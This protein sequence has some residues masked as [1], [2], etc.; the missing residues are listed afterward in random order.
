MFNH[1]RFDGK[2]SSY[3]QNVLNRLQKHLSDEKLHIVAA[4][5]AGKTILG[6]E[7]IRRIGKKC[8]ILAPTITI[9]NQWELRLK[10]LFLTDTQI[11][12]QLISMDILSPKTI[13][14]ST[15]QGLLAA[16]CGHKE[17]NDVSSADIVA[18]SDI[19]ETDTT[20]TRYEFEYEL[21]CLKDFL[22]EYK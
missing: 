10:Q 11:A 1:L 12:S 16:L 4:P 2:W 9:K 19:E 18:N 8:L 6:L 15:Y 5:G 3:Q 20:F 13:T 17:E 21:T 22:K 14:I 7:V